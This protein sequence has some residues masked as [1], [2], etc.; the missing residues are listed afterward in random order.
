MSTIKVLDGNGVEKF[1]ETIGAGTLLDPHLSIPADFIT[2]VIAGNVKGYKGFKALGERENVPIDSK[3]ADIWKGSDLSPAPTNINQIP[4]PPDVGEQMT[5]VSEDANDTN[6]GTGVH[7]VRIHYL[8][9]SGVEM[10]EDITMN[11]TTPVNMVATD[12]RFVQDMHTVAVGS[13]GFAEGNIKIYATSDSGLVYNM[14]ALGGNKSLVPH[15]MIPAGKEL[16]QA[17]WGISESGN[18][19]IAFMIRSTDMYGELLPRVF[20]PKGTK[21]LKG[22][23]ADNIILNDKI[24]AF[25]IVKVS[26]WADQ[27]GSEAS[28]SWFGVL[29]DIV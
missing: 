21:Y 19:R 12:I 24:P 4:I 25:S 6:A 27:A 26:G 11:G 8:D 28:C 29:R 5:V 16:I 7:T 22:S 20:C 14:I 9:A 2:E 23:S 10:Q 17:V 3:G 1:Y 18:Q 15:R 13:N